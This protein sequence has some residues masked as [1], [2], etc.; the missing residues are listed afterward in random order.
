MSLHPYPAKID[1]SVVQIKKLAI[2]KIGLKIPFFG[3]KIMMFLWLKN[4]LIFLFFYDLAK[5]KEK[6]SHRNFAYFM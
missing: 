5:G 4:S 2:C 1:F 3:R 6:S